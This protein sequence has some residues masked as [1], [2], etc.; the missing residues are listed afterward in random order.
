MAMD[1]T[2]VLHW[3]EAIDSF[4]VFPRVFFYGYW[5]FV[6]WY[7][8]RISFWYMSLPAV[9]RGNQESGLLAILTATLVGFGKTIYDTYTKSSRDWNAQPISTTTVATSATTT[10]IPAP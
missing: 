9:E 7:I 3:A 10:T 6:I 2:K 5:G 1:R 8:T 4:R